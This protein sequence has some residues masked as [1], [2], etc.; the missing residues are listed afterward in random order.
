MLTHVSEADA[1]GRVTYTFNA[2]L[3]VQVP[4]KYEVKG[5]VGRGAYGIV[6]SAIDTT[7]D[8][9]VAI[10]KISNVFTDIVDGRRTLREL[11]LLCFVNHPNVI[12]IKDVFHPVVEDFS[13]IYVVSELMSS[14]LRTVLKSPNV[15]L[16][17][18]HCQYL[19][20]QLLCALQY[21]HGADIVHR[22]L[23]PANI[24]TDSD[25]VV[26][27]CDFGLAR[28]VSANATT[29]VVTRW[30]RPPELLLLG[31]ECHGAVD[32]WGAA[33]LAAE[34]VT[35]RPLFPGRDYIHQLN[36]LVDVIGP[37]DLEQDLP[38]I[39]SA[40][41]L[42]YL[43]SLPKRQPLG[44]EGVQFSLKQDYTNAV[45]YSMEQDE[46][47][48][49]DSPCA[50]SKVHHGYVDKEAL[51]RVA[52]EEYTLFKDFLLKL[53]LYNPKERMTAAEALKHPWLQDIRKKCKTEGYE[54]QATEPFSWD[55]DGGNMT[56]SEVRTLLRRE[57]AYFRMSK[58]HVS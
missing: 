35:R 24:L 55:F 50:G 26:K 13:D 3:K 46:A 2:Q 23:K 15:Q 52:S 1:D 20:Y 9:S 51:D 47:E 14:D 12:S 38:H 16:M 30:Y 57:I 45:R 17:S 36:L 33:C 56:V 48:G 5:L 10:K 28:G 31:N 4:R 58:R 32:M 8:E 34:I 21:L 19:V 53:L 41:A 43:R 6:C 49:H 37:P 11:K 25:C 18:I 54:L 7:T 39:A 22:D 40:E 29:Y 27:L 44:L 42:S